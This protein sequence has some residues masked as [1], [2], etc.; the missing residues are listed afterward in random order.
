MSSAEV[1]HGLHHLRHEV[2]VT[3]T[4]AL[5]R[6]QTRHR[7]HGHHLRPSDVAFKENFEKGG[8]TVPDDFHGAHGEA[9][10]PAQ[11]GVGPGV[12]TLQ[13]HAGADHVT[14]QGPVLGDKPDLPAHQVP[15][16]QSVDDVIFANPPDLV[17]DI[18]FAHD[19][20]APSLRFEEQCLGTFTQARGDSVVRCPHVPGEREQS[21]LLLV[22]NKLRAVG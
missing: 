16:R 3:L 5:L 21:D 6:K 9:E 11:V 7:E 22:F 10:L 20:Y 17:H 13:E 15:A 2:R 4:A 14:R 18:R 8:E 19:K 12:E 1:C